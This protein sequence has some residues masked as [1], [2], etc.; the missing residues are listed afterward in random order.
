MPKNEAHTLTQDTAYELLS[1]K[2]R[3]FV[4]S[5]LRRAEGA[6]SID[7][8]AEGLA[9]WENEIPESELTDTQIKRLY[10]SLY[11]IH[12]PKLEEAELVTYDKEEGQ[13]RLTSAVSALD[14]YLPQQETAEEGWGRVATGVYGPRRRGNRAVR[15]RPA[16]P[17]GVHVALDSRPERRHRRRFPDRHRDAASPRTQMNSGNVIGHVISSDH[18]TMVLGRLAIQSKGLTK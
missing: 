1:N 13:V 8:L 17:R 2:R 18:R 4:I 7:E 6:V 16:V 5:R 12:V 3:R 15:W 10:V 14:S 11:Q 9:A